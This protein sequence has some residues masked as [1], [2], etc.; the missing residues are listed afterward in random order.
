MII[1]HQ[2]F[3]CGFKGRVNVEGRKI[4]CPL[5]GTENDFWLVDE[6]PPENH[7]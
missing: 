1:N 6:L 5:C 4:K 3:E 2:C 7:R